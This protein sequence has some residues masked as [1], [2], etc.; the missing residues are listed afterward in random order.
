MSDVASSLPVRTQNNGDVKVNVADGT[1]ESQLLGVDASG[2]V[3]VK[4]D[5]GNGNAV[6]SQINGTQ[7]ALDVGIDVAG[8]QI[9]PRS[10]RAL[11]AADVVTVD[12]GTTPWVNNIS[13]IG[14][15]AI[16][17]GQTTMSASIPVAIASNQSAIPVTQSGAWTVSATQGTSPWIVQDAADGSPTGGTAGTKSMLAGGIYNTTLPTLTNG[18]QVGLQVDS[19]G[20]LLVDISTASSITVLQGTTPWVTSD[21][22][23]GSVAAG[24]AGTKSMLAGLVY[25]TAAPSLTTGQQVALQG[26]SSGNLKVNLQ[27]ALPAGANVIGAV[28]QSGGP[29]TQNLTQ[30]G[31]AAIA[32]GQTTMSASLPVTIASNQSTLITSDLA[33][34]SPTGGTA[35]TKSML[36]GGIYNSTLPTLTTGQQASLQLDASGRLLVDIAAGTIAVTQSTSPWITSDLADGSVAGGTAG[37]KSMLAGLV[38]NTAAPTLTNGQ[39]ASLQG[40]A[41]GNL[42][43]NLQ[44]PIPAGTNL[45]GGANVYIGGSVASNTNPVPVTITSSVAG[46]AVQYYNTSVALAPAASVTFTYTVAA[47]HT[48][49]FERVW[50]SA[51]GKFKISVSNGA[52][53]IFVGFNSTANTN[54]DITITAPPLIAAAGTCSVTLTNLDILA[55]DVYATIEGNQN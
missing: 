32:L 1:T 9:D 31:G 46:T 33:N 48:F 45:I 44:T 47:S 21:L 17:L 35:A 39:Q 55:M 38:Y 52:S 16:A 28:T 12:Q 36:S 19:S 15:T 10:I 3:T 2:R 42:K 7:R 4:L 30:V 25:N 49:N 22:A 5:D 20:R 11:T 51:S 24:T 6:T 41:S 34:G 13:Q 23:D 26:D 53:V 18:Q 14:G 27:T 8:V 40:D 54:I 50:A 29:W 43:V 37:T